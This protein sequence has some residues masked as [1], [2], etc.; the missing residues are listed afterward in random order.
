MRAYSR[1]A[2]GLLAGVASAGL[3]ALPARADELQVPGTYPSI[4]AAIAAAA[5]G[6]KVLVAAGTYA[7]NVDF[8]G[9]ALTVVGLSG[10]EDTVIDGG[11]TAPAV[12]F[13]SANGPDS[14]LRG[15]TV[16][17][18]TAGI[19]IGLSFGATGAA[20]NVVD[21]VVRA[22]AGPGIF[23]WG[24]EARIDD[25]VI[26]ENT[27]PGVEF[28]WFGDTTLRNCL[29]QGN[30][31]MFFGS[32]IYADENAVVRAHN[33]T[34]VGNSGVPGVYTT[35]DAHAELVNCIVRGNTAPQ[36]ATGI[37]SL[38]V[39]H[40][41]V[42]GGFA[43]AGNLDADPLFVDAV[44]GD[45]RLQ[46]A[47]PCVDAGDSGA[48]LLPRDFFGDP[49]VGNGA[50]D[51]GFDEHHPLQGDTTTLPLGTGA[52][53]TLRLDTGPGRAGENY[54]VLGSLT[55]TSPGVPLAS[56]VLPLVPDGYF[57]HTLTHPNGAPLVDSLGVLDGAGVAQ[58]LFVLPPLDL[59]FL[60]GTTVHH[61]YASFDRAG[62][63]GPVSN[64]Y[65]ARFVD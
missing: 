43:G 12:R 46:S 54:L 18:G 44:G 8:L 31:A 35:F 39:R 58:A 52:V 41:N 49:R 26:A 34:I 13:Q 55:G 48:D 25:C 24:S 40:S 36:V 29:V 51:L 10:P 38:D 50:V 56:G 22:N 63:P 15:F 2:R 3:A 32:G 5:P 6:D 23:G 45:W 37:G 19:M 53:L 28:Q 47:S 33:C 16:T 59:P 57:L 21:C 61:A 62:V 42:E 17:N 1:A 20:P 14:T 7:E 65:G 9:K 11:G 60:V 4:Q 27:G 64:A 30:Q